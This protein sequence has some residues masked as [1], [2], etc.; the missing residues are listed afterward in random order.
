VTISDDHAAGPLIDGLKHHPGPCS[1]DQSS[2]TWIVSQ[3]GSRESYA[4]PAALN[5]LGLLRRCYVDIWCR[6]GRNLLS[7]GPS[8]TK[9]LATRFHPGIPDD[10]VISFG[11]EGVLRRSMSDLHRNRLTS[12][13]LSDR[14]CRF[15]TWFAGRVRESLK[16]AEPQPDKELFFGYNT[17]CL[18]TIEWLKRQGVFTTVDQ[19]DPGKVEEDLV[20][21]ESERWPGWAPLIGRMSQTYWERLEAEW[22]LADLIVVNSEWSASAL[23]KQGVPSE[24]VAVVP[25]AIDSVKDPGSPLRVDGTLRVL[26]LGTI[27]LRKGIQYLVD[28]A[29]RLQREDVEFLVAGATGISDDALRRFP[30]NMTLLGRITRDQLDSTYRRAHVFVLP[31]LS[32]GF[33]MTQLEAMAHGLPV[34]TTRNC[35]RMVTDGYDG[36]IVPPR[37]GAALAEA[38]IRLKTNRANLREMSVAALKTA[39]AYSLPTNARL[40]HSAALR[41]RE[42]MK[43]PELANG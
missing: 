11:F 19:V 37:D 16:R 8:A 6:W 13:Q 25:L 20:I 12:S 33:A 5:R 30:S 36:L 15:G 39:S 2:W 22:E 9:A 32:D 1:G 7:H 18:E 26:W 3:E 28:A 21:E 42:V 24:K 29:R 40:L 34:I 10:K 38:I 23:V 41:R 27:I 31:T 4:V 17:N 35:G 14:Y 43:V